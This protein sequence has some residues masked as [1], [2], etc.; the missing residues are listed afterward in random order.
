MDAPRSTP[1][2]VGDDDH[3]KRRRNRT[4]QSCL[5]CHTSK[6]M[7]WSYVLTYWLVYSSY[8]FI[9]V[10][11][12]GRAVAAPSSGLYVMSDKRGLPVP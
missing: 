11:E 9:S 10:I 6:R 5:Q 2:N 7:V 3:R 8:L 1:T 4:T 12:K